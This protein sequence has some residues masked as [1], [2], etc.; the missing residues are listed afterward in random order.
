MILRDEEVGAMTMQCDR[1][2]NM[3]DDYNIDAFQQMIDDAKEE[4]WRIERDE[5]AE[6]GWSHTCPDHDAKSR[7]EDQRRLLGL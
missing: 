3:T 7:I 5:N 2:T 1:C 4:G 6:G